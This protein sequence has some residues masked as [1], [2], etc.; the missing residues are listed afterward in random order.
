MADPFS[1]APFARIYDAIYGGDTVFLAA[2][3]AFLRGILAGTD[4]PWLDAGCGTGTHL[5]AL[6]SPKRPATG[7]DLDAAML[8]VAE[9]KLRW[10]GSTVRL[11]HSDMALLPFVTAAF[12]AL[13]CLESPLAYLPDDRS[14]ALA[15]EGFHRVLRRGGVLVADIFDYVGSLGD[16]GPRAGTTR[17]HTLR[18]IIDVRE[19]H[20]YHRVTGIW[21]M[22]Q[23]FTIRDTEEE[24]FIVRH[25]L[26]IRSADDYADALER[27]GFRVE[28]SLPL[29]P[30]IPPESQQELRMIFVARS[31]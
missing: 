6:G 5:I 20:R 4:G 17:F 1:A 27:A 26:R 22:R 7:L 15:L 30:G 9:E 16:Q 31:K 13:V 21:E 23:A 24:R 25:R 10:A 18:G 12:G 11:V 29:Y 19:A 14:L 2:Q 28:Q 8:A 3:L